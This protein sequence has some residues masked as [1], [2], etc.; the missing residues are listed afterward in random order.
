MDSSSHDLRPPRP[1]RTCRGTG[2]DRS[3]H[4]RFTGG[5]RDDRPCPVCHGE[6]MIQPETPELDDPEERRPK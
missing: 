6:G 1:C 2:V 5:V 4:F 3:T